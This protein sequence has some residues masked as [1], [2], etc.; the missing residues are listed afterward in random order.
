MN[1]HDAECERACMATSREKYYRKMY[2]TLI[3]YND[4]NGAPLY[5]DNIILAIHKVIKEKES[6]AHNIT[7]NDQNVTADTFSQTSN[8]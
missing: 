7:L 2:E 3:D 5:N 8:T 6:D 4:R 1:K